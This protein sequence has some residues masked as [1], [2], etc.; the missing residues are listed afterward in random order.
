MYVCARLC[1]WPGV[2]RARALL[3]PQLHMH[4][5]ESPCRVR[6]G[7]EPRFCFVFFFFP[8]VLFFLVMKLEKKIQF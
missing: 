5:C 6:K 2:Q 8:I 4:E 7:T 3:E 1:W